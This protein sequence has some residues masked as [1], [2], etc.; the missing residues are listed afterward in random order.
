MR[1]RRHNISEFEWIVHLLGSDEATDMSD[2]SHQV[3][4]DAVSDLAIAGVVKISRIATGATEK[5]IW[6]ELSHG[7]LKRVHVNDTRFFVH[8]VGL[9]HEVV[10]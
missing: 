5:D 7:R 10:A 9:A 1:R 2:V 4:S 3:G 6:T 8:K